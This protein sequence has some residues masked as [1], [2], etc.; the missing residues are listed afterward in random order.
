MHNYQ[1]KLKR[2]K[3]SSFYGMWKLKD[4]FQS[5]DLLDISSYK[6]LILKSCILHMMN[7]TYTDVNV[8][9]LISD[10]GVWIWWARE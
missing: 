4:S 6:N 1:D 10:F 5:L 9:F 7:S 3:W 2:A 8:Y